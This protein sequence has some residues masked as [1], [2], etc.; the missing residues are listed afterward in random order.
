MQCISI[1]FCCFL[2]NLEKKA[3]E[4]GKE[5]DN[6]RKDNISLREKLRGLRNELKAILD[7]NTKNGIKTECH[8]VP[9]LPELTATMPDETSLMRG[10]NVSPV[11]V[12]TQT[13]SL[14]KKETVLAV[15]ISQV[16]EDEE[17]N[18]DDVTDT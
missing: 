3:K 8:T 7:A 17:I 9:S 2:Q 6:L 12:A 10:D 15:E 4:A 14:A 11:S 5:R 1:V 13:M 18:V 16:S